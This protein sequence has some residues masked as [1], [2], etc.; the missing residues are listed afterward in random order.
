[1]EPRVARAALAAWLAF[2]FGALGSSQESLQPVAPPGVSSEPRAFREDSWLLLLSTSDLEERERNFD[3]LVR[4][5]WA[6]PLALVFL[7]RLALDQ[8]RKD[9]AWTARLALRELGQG[10]APVWMPTGNDAE[11]DRHLFALFESL[12]T[13]RPELQFGV[14]I[15]RAEGPRVDVGTVR[16]RLRQRSGEARLEWSEEQNGEPFTRTFRGPDLKSI[17]GENPVL[18]ERI[19]LGPAPLTGPL[20]LE[21]IV[22]RETPLQ[23]VPPMAIGEDEAAEGAPEVLRQAVVTVP[24][25]ILGVYVK[26][27]TADERARAGLPAGSGLRVLALDPGTIADALGVR[28]GDMLWRVN[29]RVLTRPLDIA[30]TLQAVRSAVPGIPVGLSTHWRIPP[31]GFSRQEPIHRG[32]TLPDR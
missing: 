16:V 21:L 9:L 26:K 31:G 32:T 3:A 29:G 23:A 7:E 17:L 15:D 12:S 11:L 6:D 28:V 1:M 13:T 30:E 22:P 24:T 5:A 4:R 20:D 18:A 14:P 2:S 19:R 25:E 27:L 8:E 10:A